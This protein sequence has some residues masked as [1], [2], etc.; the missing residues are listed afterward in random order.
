MALY[1]QV[2][3]YSFA[4]ELRKGENDLKNRL[5]SI[6]IDY[7]FLNKF[8]QSNPILNGLPIIANLR[9]GAW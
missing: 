7:Q 4:K 2:S 6:L 1:H 8:L 5:K 3:Q 9:C